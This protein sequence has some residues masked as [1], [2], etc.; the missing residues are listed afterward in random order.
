M[1]QLLW[2]ERLDCESPDGSIAVY[3]MGLTKRSSLVL[4]TLFLW[5]IRYYTK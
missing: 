4:L 3:Y 1:L 2:R 5:G